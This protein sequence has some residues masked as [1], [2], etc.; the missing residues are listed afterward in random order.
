M[1]A[2]LFITRSVMTTVQYISPAESERLGEPALAAVTNLAATA[3]GG[4]Y[5]WRISGARDNGSPLFVEG[6][7]F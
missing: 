2:R 6:I 7:T 4:R 5:T 1:L 3:D